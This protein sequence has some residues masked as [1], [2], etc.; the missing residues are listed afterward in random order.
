MDACHCQAS[1]QGG[2]GETCGAYLAAGAGRGRVGAGSRGEQLRSFRSALPEGLRGGRRASAR[3][4]PLAGDHA[5]L[6]RLWPKCHQPHR[7]LPKL[8]PGQALG[9]PATWLCS[10]PTLPRKPRR[11][12]TEVASPTCEPHPCAAT[13]TPPPRQ[14]G[15]RNPGKGEGPLAGRAAAWRKRV[16]TSGR[17]RGCPWPAELCQPSSRGRP[18]GG[19]RD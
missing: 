12:R 8:T 16:H 17:G 4:G 19:E 15:E 3:V 6:P 10:V 9:R 7:R 1:G 13:T 5:A 14:T 2:S 18:R 11:R